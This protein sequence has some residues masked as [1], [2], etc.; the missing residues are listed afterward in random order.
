LWCC[1]R[2]I[3]RGLDVLGDHFGPEGPTVNG[4]IFKAYVDLV[5]LALQVGECQ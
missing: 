4:Q 1:K 2:R 3:E 5:R